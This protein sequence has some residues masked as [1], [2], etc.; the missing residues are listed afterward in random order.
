MMMLIAR[1]ADLLASVEYEKSIAEPIRED[2]DL[3]ISLEFSDWGQN[4][5]ACFRQFTQR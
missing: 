4:R 1:G 3:L 2:P 5:G